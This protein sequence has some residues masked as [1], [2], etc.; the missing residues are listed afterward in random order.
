[1]AEVRLHVKGGRSGDNTLVATTE[2]ESWPMKPDLLRNTRRGGG[3]NMVV[4]SH[5]RGGGMINLNTTP[6]I[7]QGC[8]GRLC[9]GQ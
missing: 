3:E 7:L 6:W 2:A 5:D 8:A 1:M 9:Q 4:Y